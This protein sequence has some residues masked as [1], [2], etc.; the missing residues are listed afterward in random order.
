MKGGEGLAGVYKDLKIE[1]N[2]GTHRGVTFNHVIATIDLEKLTQLSPNNPATAAAMKSMFGGETLHSWF[3]TDGKRVFQITEPAWPGV[4]ARID[5][6]LDGHARIGESRGFQSVRSQLP[7]Q[8][9][10]LVILSSQGV[11]R[12]F[13]NQLAATLNKPELKAPQDLPKE[14][15]FLGASLTPR[16]PAGYEFHLVIPSQAG[17]IFEKGLVPLFQSIKPPDN[18]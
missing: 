5:A 1:S 2:V 3:G 17:P 4:K 10:L 13:A 18:P 6:F 12:M 15:V 14:D 16:R 7:E 8:A 11:V 9:S